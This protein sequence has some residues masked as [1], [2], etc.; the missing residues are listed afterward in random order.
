MLIKEE[1]NVGMAVDNVEAEVAGVETELS[2]EVIAEKLDELIPEAKETLLNLPQFTRAVVASM[3]D[4]VEDP[5]KE[6]LKK[7]PGAVRFRLDNMEMQAGVGAGR[8]DV[9]MIVAGRD[10]GPG[11]WDEGLRLQRARRWQAKTPEGTE[12]VDD[13]DSI[14]YEERDNNGR[15]IEHK[16]TRVAIEK[17][18]DFLSKLTS[19][20]KPIE[21]PTASGLSR[22]GRLFTRPK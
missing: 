19:P 15:R 14:S 1:F 6:S 8:I 9:H 2:Q 7:Y 10:Y 21:N 13:E 22:L 17:A 20:S 3:F 11:N 16:N 4:Q 18:K 5:S 12:R